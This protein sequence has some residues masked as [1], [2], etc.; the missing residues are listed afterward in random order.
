MLRQSGRGPFALD[1]LVDKPFFISGVGIAELTTSKASGS[2][3]LWLFWTQNS[4][5][6]PSVATLPRSSSPRPLRW[7]ALKWLR[8]FDVAAARKPSK[9]HIQHPFFAQKHIPTQSQNIHVI[10][11]TKKK[12]SS[13]Q[14]HFTNLH[15][16]HFSPNAQPFYSCLYFSYL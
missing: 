3:D 11:N 2:D 16:L 5:T 15:C 8:P 6:V 7:L 1:A 10:N 9:A 12:K 14:V 4:Y 13:S